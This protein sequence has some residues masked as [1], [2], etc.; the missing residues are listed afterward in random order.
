MIWYG[1]GKLVWQNGPD[2]IGLYWDLWLDTA[3][4]HCGI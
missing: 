2:L 4:I 1:I 3:G